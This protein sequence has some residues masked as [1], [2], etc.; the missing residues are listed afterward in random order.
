MT[1]NSVPCVTV[2]SAQGPLVLKVEE[3][4]YTVGV[5]DFLFRVWWEGGLNE[6][7]VTY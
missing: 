4:I 7:H 6:T 2:H 1:E 3:I 5:S